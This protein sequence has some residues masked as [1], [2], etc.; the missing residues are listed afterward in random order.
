MGTPAVGTARGRRLGDTATEARS[1][2]RLEVV[3][4]FRFRGDAD[5]LLN[6]LAE[7]APLPPLPPAPRPEAAAPIPDAPGWS[8]LAV[9][10]PLFAVVWACF[11]VLGANVAAPPAADIAGLG[12]LL[13]TG[14]AIVALVLTTLAVADAQISGRGPRPAVFAVVALGVAQGAL[15]ASL[16]SGAHHDM[17]GVA[18]WVFVFVGLAV[19]LAWV[20]GH[21]QCG[22]RRQR[23]EHTASLTAS[24]IERA[25]R[26]AHQT[27][28]SVHRHDVRSMLFLIDGAGRTLVDHSLSAEQRASFGEMLNEGVQRLGA[29]MDVRAEEIQPFAVDDVARAV[30][31]AE[32]KAGRR[33]TAELPA[34][35][36]ARGRAADVAA[37]VRTLVAVTGRN[38]AH[39][40]QLV[41]EV[42]D[43]AIVL[44]VESTGDFR[45]LP[46]VTGNWEQISA[47]SFK[48]SRQ[49]DEE[50][51]D[52][53][54]AA[55]LLTEQGADL[56]STAGRARFAV[57]LPFADSDAREE[58]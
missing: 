16:G 7:P 58:A 32:R 8:P 35:L 29:L 31:H 48:R 47:E 49:N 24:W 22:I 14:A 37:V 30:V 45:T 28:E 50:S 43:G 3:R 56:W 33:V 19:P 2:D 27:V 21:F 36:T 25:R 26:Q 38:S 13:A 40:V 51:V 44:R 23:V 1:S 39:S 10:L 20:G 12:Q 52:L 55:R 4:A 41:G 15:A 57:R 42:H 34:G 46:L 17:W 6:A 11:T 5:S 18:A 54:V 9:A 53:Y